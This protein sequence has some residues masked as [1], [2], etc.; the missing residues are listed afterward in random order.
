MVVEAGPRLGGHR[1]LLRSSC[2]LLPF[3]LSPKPK[4]QLR[5]G[6][7]L[8]Y[9]FL[10]LDARRKLLSTREAPKLL[11][12]IGEFCNIDSMLSTSSFSKPIETSQTF[13]LRNLIV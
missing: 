11:E 12:A 2:T 1:A 5:I 6:S 4:K 10:I 3:D 8:A 13:H 9:V 7:W